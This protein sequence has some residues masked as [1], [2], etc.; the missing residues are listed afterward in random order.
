MTREV[1]EHL[2]ERTPQVER[3][4]GPELLR[5]PHG[6]V[7]VAEGRARQAGQALVRAFEIPRRRLTA[8]EEHGRDDSAHLSRV[9]FRHQARPACKGERFCRY[10]R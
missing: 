1:E 5:G 7:A 3:D 8:R 10:D 9:R 2:Q 4:P 6:E